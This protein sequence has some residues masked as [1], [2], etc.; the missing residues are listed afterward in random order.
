MATFVFITLRTDKMSISNLAGLCSE[1]IE[2][3]TIVENSLG[4][5]GVANLRKLV[6][7]TVDLKSLMSR[8]R[9][10]I[11]TPQIRLWDGNRDVLLADVDRTA[12]TASKSSTPA[13]AEAGT[14]VYEFLHAFKDLRTAKMPTQTSQIKQLAERYASFPEYS[15]AAAV[16]GLSNTFVSL[17]EA[18]LTFEKL[19]AQRLNELATSYTPAATGV[20][21]TTAKSYEDFCIVV[22]QTLNA[23]PSQE[24]EQLFFAMND[25]R[26]KYIIRTPRKSA[27]KVADTKAEA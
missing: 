15:E 21:G 7:S 23:I 27:E 13:T 2:Q 12:K 16:I 4:A 8:N 24:L 3:A 10:S 25:L 19:Y 14:K 1:T 5:L 22:A 17:F 11:F 26:R 9:K 20:R 6:A 18:N